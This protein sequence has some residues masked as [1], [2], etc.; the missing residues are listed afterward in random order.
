M[1]NH[2][3]DKYYT[4]WVI[5]DD[6]EI[7]VRILVDVIVAAFYLE[8]EIGEYFEV[9]YRWHPISREIISI[10]GSIY[11]NFTKYIFIMKPHFV[12]IH[13]STYGN[14]FQRNFLA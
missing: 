4:P 14:G 8:S 2:N 5:R 6:S 11:L 9:V 7:L 10:K 1:E 12:N 13:Y 3:D